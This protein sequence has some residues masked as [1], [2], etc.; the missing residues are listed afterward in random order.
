MN[1]YF[2]AVV[3]DLLRRKLIQQRRDFTFETVMSHPG[4]V[5]L[6][7]EARAKGCR[8]YL[9]YMATDDP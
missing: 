9:Y 3:V 4:K 8:T 1:A 6:L 2:A 5:E 7:A